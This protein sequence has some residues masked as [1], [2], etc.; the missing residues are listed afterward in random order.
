MVLLWLVSTASVG[1]IDKT[2][3]GGKV[4]Q[5]M[6]TKGQQTDDDWG[7]WSRQIIG[8]GCWCWWLYWI[9]ITDADTNTAAAAAAAVADDADA[10]ANAAAVAD[11]ADD[12]ADADAA[13]VAADADDYADA[14]NLLKG[15]RSRSWQELT[16]EQRVAC[17]TQ[18]PFVSTDE[19][20]E[21]E[22]QE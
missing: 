22:V 3:A 2:S 12:Y 14:D 8:H 21:G 4:L 10:D 20:E 15:G 5:L 11:D 18:P 6:K 1:L 19:E 17:P 9:S 13:A 16:D 7:A